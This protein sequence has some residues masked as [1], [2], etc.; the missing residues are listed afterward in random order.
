MKFCRV[1][2]FSKRKKIICAFLIALIAISVVFL[3]H[4]L[5]QSIFT[6]KSGQE[7]L[8]PIYSVETEEKKI[9]ISF[10]AAWGN[11][12]TQQLIDIGVIIRGVRC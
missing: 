6:V 4:T 2:W 5:P 10:D 7:K 1:F 3:Y 11:E 9:S 12:D 8:L